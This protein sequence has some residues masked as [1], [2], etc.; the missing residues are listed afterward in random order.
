MKQTLTL[1]TALLLAPLAALQA[2]GPLKASTK[3]NVVYMLADDLDW[4]DAYD[5][6]WESPSKDATESM[7]GGGGSVGLNVWAEP[8]GD[9]LCLVARPDAFEEN[10]GLLK[11]GRVRLR[12]SPNP[13]D[14]GQ[15]FRQQLRL[16]EGVIE[17]RAVK[18]GSS[19]TVRVWSEIRRPVVHFDIECSTPLRMEAFYEN[20]RMAP[21]QLHEFNWHG[22]TPQR[23][24]LSMADTVT[25]RNGGV[26]FFHR[27]PERGLFDLLVAKYRL[28]PVQT[29]LWNPQRWRTAGGRLRG[30]GFVADTDSTTRREGN[31]TFRVW[32]LASDGERQRASLEMALHTAQTESVEQWRA[33]LT[34]LAAR[35]P[36]DARAEAREWWGQFW[37]RSRIAINARGDGSES[38]ARADAAWQVGRNYQLVRFLLACNAYGAL[39]TKFNGGLHTARAP[40][41]HP[42]VRGWGSVNFTGQNQRLLYWPLLKSGDSDL[43]PPQLDFYAHM[44]RNGEL[45]ARAFWGIEDAAC[46]IDQT[47]YFGLPVGCHFDLAGA[48]L[49]SVEEMLK[50][51][52]LHAH[53]HSTQIEL[54]W[55]M[56]E[57]A[58][59][60]GG[61][62][63][64]YVPFIEST[65]RF[66]NEY[67]QLHQRRRNGQPYGAD[68]KL[69]IEPAKALESYADVRNPTDVATGLRV[70]LQR[71]VELPDRLVPPERKTIWR[72]MLRRLPAP[73]Y[74]ADYNG[75]RVILPGEKY[76]RRTNGE[77]PQLYVLFP[78][79]TWG[80][81]RPGLDVARDSWRYG[82]PGILN[83]KG[84]W[85]WY[86]NNIFTARLGLT[87]EARD[88]T[89]AK[90]INGPFRFPGLWGPAFDET[91]D[92]DHGGCG[93]IGLQD[94]LLQEHGDD[95]YL[96]PAWPAEWPV[97]F[98]LHA[99]GVTLEG[100]ARHGALER[101][102]VTVHDAPRR[103]LR[104]HAPG[105]GKARVFDIVAG[106]APEAIDSRAST[107]DSLEFVVAAGHTFRLDG[108]HVPPARPVR[109]SVLLAENLASLKLPLSRRRDTTGAWQSVLGSQPLIQTPALSGADGAALQ[110]VAGS[111]IGYDFGRQVRGT[112]RMRARATS[113]QACGT[114]EILNADIYDNRFGKTVA[115]LAQGK[116]TVF[117]QAYGGIMAGANASG[118][119]SLFAAGDQAYSSQQRLAWQPIGAGLPIGAGWTEIVLDATRPGYMTVR[120][121]NLADGK[122]EQ[123]KLKAISLIGGF[124][125]VR[126]GSHGEPGGGVWFADL[127][128]SELESPE[129][130]AGK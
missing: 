14:N 27:N 123:T 51:L 2:A 46:F 87:A 36:A 93:M 113:A 66:Y 30:E 17:L 85:C 129:T 8:G 23:R 89:V 40:G 84:W 53:Y 74:F 48:P 28:D 56:L 41:V 96:L 11:A 68:G 99:G 3:P 18:N 9:L 25:V 128:V 126:L 44:R 127:E 120:V 37:R 55:M 79:N 121:T 42:D 57:W 50:G 101:L 19:A 38:D 81:G 15:S 104:L 60:G 59:Y 124:R 100:A 6:V 21:F 118:T 64:A 105:I 4:L 80:V 26:E 108:L 1:F 95:L 13:F 103:R 78:Y 73:V 69:V 7:P 33:D 16:R 62:L 47:S 88:Y 106:A 70:V 112:V 94:M 72:E 5:V 114:V 34:A 71:V 109:R 107:D 63:A 61:D 117:D 65:L 67:Y 110:T 90:L 98:K 49:N 43:L 54:S 75:R 45:F 20:W 77:I 29:Q 122:T 58:R 10:G 130:K 12:L 97:D 125:G 31:L 91:P 83:D 86:Q 22:T 119:W 52:G 32:R 76:G 24:G 102:R 111:V 39:P 115:N 35:A 116:P 82:G 92:M